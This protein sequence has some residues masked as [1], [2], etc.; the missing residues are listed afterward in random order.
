MYEITSK[1]ILDL[2]K[3]MFRFTL[4]RLDGQTPIRYQ[5]EEARPT[6]QEIHESKKIKELLA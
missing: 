2:N 3:A 6:Q 5:N 1:E 4:Q